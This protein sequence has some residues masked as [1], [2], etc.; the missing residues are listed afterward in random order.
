MT[1]ER[2]KQIRGALSR[3]RSLHLLEE[4]GV[5]AFMRGSTLNDIISNRA[6]HAEAERNRE[7][8]KARDK[9]NSGPSR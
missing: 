1:A 9:A 3:P 4:I 2:E 6:E 7:A 8:E 5:D